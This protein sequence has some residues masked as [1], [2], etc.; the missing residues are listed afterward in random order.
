MNFIELLLKKRE[1]LLR[2]LPGLQQKFFLKFTFANT[3][4][5]TKFLAKDKS[6][7]TLPI[8]R[9]LRR[10]NLQ[11]LAIKKSTFVE[12]DLFNQSEIES[13]FGKPLEI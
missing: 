10:L 3:N 5:Q 1:D 12:L 7:S 2:Q 13:L 8:D 11:V 9:A 6:T 4:Y